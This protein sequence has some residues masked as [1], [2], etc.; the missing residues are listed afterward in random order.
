MDR[1]KSKRASRRAMNTKIISEVDQLLQ[2]QQFAL[3]AL[4]VVHGRLR[5]SNSALSALNAELEA[6]LTDDQASEDY[7]SVMEYEDAAN[8]A[9]ALLEHHM[10]VLKSSSTSQTSSSLDDASG[11]RIA[12]NSGGQALPATREFG[13]R[14]PKL[15]LL[16]FDGAITRWQPFWEMFRHLV[17]EN[18]RLS[19]TDRFHYL[20][21][22]LDGAA[23][24]AVAGIQITESSYSDAL[25]VLKNRFGNV[26]LIE[27]KHLENLRMLR[28]VDLSSNVAALRKLYDTVQ[29]NRRGLES[30]GI[31]MSSYAAMLNEVILKVIPSDIVADYLKRQSLA[32]SRSSTSSQVSSEQE[33]E[34]LL[35]FLR[36]EVE[37]RERSCQITKPPRSHDAERGSKKQPF[38][39]AAAVLHN[40]AKTS[41]CFFCAA[42]DH[43]TEECSGDIDLADKRTR[44][45]SDGRCFRCTGKGHLVRSCRRKVQCQS[46]KRRHATT[47][48]TYRSA[49]RPSSEWAG[50]TR[51]AA[52]HIATRKSAVPRLI[53]D[54]L[55]QTFRAWM[56]TSSHCCYVRGVFDNGSQRTFIR[57]DVVA[58][59]KLKVTGE[60]DLAISAF[61]RSG[62]PKKEF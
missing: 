40:K 46:C 15:E 32:A 58:K 1:V 36:V 59:L 50:K 62:G 29:M 54:V 24:E 12:A 61:G 2:S 3:S 27:Q 37:G 7:T 10:D 34:H 41:A 9:L 18:P 4:R 13:A 51:Q 28:P 55:L 31:G 38:I 48:C 53:S 11:D 23:A 44:L 22:L 30:L 33:I 47:M 21:S 45:S 8:S 6:H 42:T 35:S 26:K 43:R 20:V 39:P 16:R 19:N 49:K 56:T 5:A 57:E 25:D 52:M 17:H 60:V 14:L